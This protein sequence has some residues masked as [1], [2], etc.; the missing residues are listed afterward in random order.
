MCPTGVFQAHYAFSLDAVN[1]Q[2]SPRQ[3]YS[4]DTEYADGT[5]QLFTRVERPQLGFLGGSIDGDSN[6]PNVLYNG[7]C[8][9]STPKEVY[10]CLELK[11]ASPVMTWTL[12]RKLRSKTDDPE[13]RL[14]GGAP[15]RRRKGSSETSNRSPPHV[16][17]V[18]ADDLGW[19][20]AGFTQ[21]PLDR[22]P[23]SSS[24]MA[25][26]LKE[27]AA[28]GAVLSRLY[29]FHYC[30]PARSAVLT[31]RLPVHVFD[32]GPSMRLNVVNQS[33]MG[34]YGIPVGMNTI[35]TTL[36]STHEAH[37]VGKYDVGFADGLQMPMSRGF[38]SF[39]GYLGGQV[40]YWSATAANI[41][42]CS[43]SAGNQIVDLWNGSKPASALPGFAGCVG[44]DSVTC[45][46]A[47]ASSYLESIFVQRV[48]SIIATYA[49]ASVAT[50]NNDGK[51]LFLYYG[52]HVAHA[53][54]QSPKTVLGRFSGIENAN[55]R[56]YAAQ[57]AVCDSAVGSVVDAL[58][59]TKLWG[60]A[61][62]I[63]FSDNGGPS[64][65]GG[66]PSASNFPL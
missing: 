33:T 8:A 66:P 61:I 56:I 27:L 40:D 12:A 23:L 46:G 51:A 36:S 25:P 41:F 55:R 43:P 32:A 37:M 60:R 9:A 58:H 16:V 45:G 54:L 6:S 1:W 21:Q 62:F 14:T 65:A 35:A 10:A 53:P 18:V 64:Y 59:Q 7:V 34:V 47:D 15:I 48:E 5:S 13:G 29:S 3:T 26:R 28:G 49:K 38:A 17:M 52:Q 42:S 19:F 30:S 50:H 57:V 39:F 22:M 11:S 63:F 24:T 4:Y 20:N 31:G 44:K 2:I